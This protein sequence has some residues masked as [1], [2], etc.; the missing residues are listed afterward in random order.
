MNSIGN[1][2]QLKEMT[3]Y[4]FVPKAI[5]LCKNNK[6]LEL[7]FNNFIDHFGQINELYK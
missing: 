5:N 6:S 2:N 3:D 7:Y 1:I 4:K